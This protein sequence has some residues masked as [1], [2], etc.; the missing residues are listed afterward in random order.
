MAGR[1]ICS[2]LACVVLFLPR[3]CQALENPGEKEQ[4]RRPPAVR[5]V[6]LYAGH[7]ENILA[8]GRGDVLVGVSQGDDPSLFPGIPRLPA[9][10]DAERILSLAP[11]LV[12][13]RP[14]TEALLG[15]TMEALERSGVPVVSLEP[16]SWD[17]MESYLSVLGELV[18]AQGASAR[19]KSLLS[20]M[21]GPPLG[22][23]RPRVFLESSAKGLKTCSPTSWAAHVIALAGGENAAASATPLRE[24][25][26]LAE[27][28]EER[29]LSLAA[30]G[31]QVYLVQVG[32]MN[33]VSEE[34]VLSRPWI[35]GLGGARIALVPEEMLSRP[36]LLRVREGVR[37]LSVLFSEGGNP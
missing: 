34:E 5:V 33:P 28:G 13:V 16:P 17:G 20:G 11:D 36:S 14:L 32:P 22:P 25:S 21:E 6:S 10:P 12:L 29:L 15:G 30:G 24:G 37:R 1:L 19:W 2:I 35:R 26:P 8:L 31:L 27:W 4:A 9:R 3:G 18:G 7:S 23:V